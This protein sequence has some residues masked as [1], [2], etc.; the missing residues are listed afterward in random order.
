MKLMLHMHQIRDFINNRHDFYNKYY[1]NID[2]AFYHY[3]GMPNAFNVGIVQDIAIKNHYLGKKPIFENMDNLDNENR[4]ICFGMVNNYL[5]YYKEE[6]LH[7]FTTPQF[8]VPL[9]NFTVLAT[10]DL[11]AETYYY[12]EPVLLE[13]KT[14]AKYEAL[15]FQTMF[16]CWASWRWNFK[17]PKYVLKRTLS[18]PRI[19]LKKGED[20]NDYIKRLAEY[21]FKI[22]VGMREINKS[23]VE[24][25]DEQ[26]KLILNELYTCL[27]NPKRF[28]RQSGDYWG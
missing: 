21:K 5:D 3:R 28:Y 23:M 26:L 2:P 18:K 13:I 20:I 25:F 19:K 4:A 11:M 9:T 22:Q 12:N 17:I 27:K 24:R 15:D 14:G 10:P 7:S 8:T 1:N 16:Y 6:K